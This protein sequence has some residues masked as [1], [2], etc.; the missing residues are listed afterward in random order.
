ML[1]Y[2]AYALPTF[3]LIESFRLATHGPAHLS[4]P[5]AVASPLVVLALAALL[6]WAGVRR[7]A[8]RLVG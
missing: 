4:V 3:H 5:W 7:M 8:T 6:G 1:P 2:L